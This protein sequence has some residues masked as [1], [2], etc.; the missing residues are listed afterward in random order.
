MIYFLSDAHLGSRVMEDPAGHQQKLVNLLMRMGEDAEA[1]YL[2]GD[3]FDYWYEYIWPSSRTSKRA[4]FGPVLDAL[5]ALT[6]RGIAVHFFIGNHDIWTFGWLAQETGVIVHKQPETI[7]LYGKRVFLGHGDGIAPRDIMRRVPKD[8]QKR[9]RRFMLLRAIF[10]CPLAQYPYR[11]MPTRWADEIGYEWARRSRL[12]ELA[13]PCSYKGED[14]EELVLFAK[15]Q[16][17]ICDYYIFGHRH[18][19]LQLMLASGSQVIILGEFF[20]QWT[21]AA[22][23]PNGEIELRFDD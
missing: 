12:K 15:E 20:Q 3:I 23:S 9:I 11:L 22:M 21:Y 10:H 14:K 6:T 19:E 16:G 4:M 7:E 1:I 5:K 17:S 8:F 13:H 18:I 2:L